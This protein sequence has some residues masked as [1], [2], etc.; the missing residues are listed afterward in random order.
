MKSLRRSIRH[1][2]TKC[3]LLTLTMVA[4]LQANALTFEYGE[5]TYVTTSDTTVRLAYRGWMNPYHVT[6]HMEIPSTVS[7][8]GIEYSVSEIS[9][10]AFSNCGIT[11]LIIPGT[12]KRIGTNSFYRC[13]LTE[14]ILKEGVQLIDNSAFAGCHQLETLTLPSSITII[15]SG[16]FTCQALKSVYIKGAASI[17]TWAFQT[18]SAL[19][20]VTLGKDVSEVSSKAFTRCSKLTEITIEDGENIFNCDSEAFDDAP[21]TTMYIGRDLKSAMPANHCNTLEHVTIG[22]RVTYIV[23][24]MFSDCTKLTEIVIPNSV[25]RIQEYAFEDCIGL[26]EVVIG[27]GVEKISNYAF[28]N[29]TG[30]TSLTMGKNIKKIGRG[31]FLDCTGLSSEDVQF[32]DSLETINAHAFTNCTGLTEITIPSNVKRLAA[33]VFQGC[34]KLKKVVIDDTP[35]EIY[36]ES[37]SAIERGLEFKGCPLQEVYMGRNQGRNTCFDNVDDDDWPLSDISDAPFSGFKTLKKVTISDQVT[38]IPEYYYAFTGIYTVVI[39]NSVKSIQRSAFSGC[40]NLN[41]IV[42]GMGLNTIDNSVFYTESLMAVYS[43]KMVPPTLAN[44]VFHYSTTSEGTLYVP[45]GS[46]AA[47]QSAIGW[48]EF[49]NIVEIDSFDEAIAHLDEIYGHIPGDING[50]GVVNIADANSVIEVIINGGGNGHGRSPDY[51]GEIHSTFVYGDINSDGVVNIGDINTVI[52]LI[53]TK[54]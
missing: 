26:E 12:V 24:F 19:E 6:G 37:N 25:T 1:A 23:Q 31:A 52:N 46:K 36:F 14:L 21:I 16:A 39:P 29:C 32:P 18:C 41:A 11:S 33:S 15:K 20:H 13:P 10:N 28:Q 53:L 5:F 40:S 47:Y 3:L 42:L 27:D 50:D 35:D 17:D 48:K 8:E 4:T 2:T 9:D 22:P 54:E 7:Y 38:W 30:L 49:R 51:Y 44:Q 45:T 34:S 43:M